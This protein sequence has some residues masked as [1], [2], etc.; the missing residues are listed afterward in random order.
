MLPGDGVTDLG[1]AN[2]L[3]GLLSGHINIPTEA[4]TTGDITEVGSIRTDPNSGLPK[5]T[6][7]GSIRNFLVQENVV[8]ERANW[9]KGLI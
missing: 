3:L 9:A 7:A 6:Q 5:V 2:G 4:R 1:W 8:E